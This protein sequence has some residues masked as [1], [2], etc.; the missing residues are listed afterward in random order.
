MTYRLCN[1]LLWLGISLAS[2]AQVPEGFHT[3]T[4]IPY[5]HSHNDYTHR[6]PLW[7][8]LENGFTSVEIDIY[9]AADG[10]LRVSH[11]PLALQSK[12]TLEALYLAPLR[13]W[14]DRNGGRVYADTDITLTLMIDLK[15]D[16]NATYPIL[17]QVLL[18]YRDYLTI[19]HGTEVKK[20]PLRILLSG[21]RPEE[22]I[23]LETEQWVSLDGSLGVDYTGKNLRVDRQSA[24]F[25]SRFKKRADG[26]LSPS[27]HEQ[28]ARWV[29]ETTEKGR[30]IRFWAAGNNP[31]L[32]KTLA[33]AGVTTL[34]ADKP[35]LFRQWV[36]RYEKSK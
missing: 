1:I 26:R 23:A 20:G 5:G 24:S 22:A 14:I 11:L 29:K 13:Q 6:R 17:K 21:S 34:N 16:G 3:G 36:L 28:L 9:T 10:S 2:A 25:G 12:P 8:A 7:E 31:R 35:A 4:P 19:Y 27:E 15:G 32:W 18:P 33:D 30:E